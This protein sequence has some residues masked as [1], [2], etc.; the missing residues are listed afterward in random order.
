MAD[1]NIQRTTPTINI[2][3]ATRNYHLPIA[4]ATTLGGIKVG[5]N[6]TI[7]ED[8]TLNSELTEYDL[9]VA[10]S[11]TLGG[12]KIGSSLSI[13]DGVA[14]VTVDS[15]LDSDSSNPLRNSV[16]TSYINDL[17]SAIQDAGSSLTSLST[18]VGTLSNTV[19]AHTTAISTM[20]NTL[21]AHTSAIQANSDNISTQ[22][23]SISNNTYAIGEL[24][25]RLINA[26]GSITT[27]SDSLDV[28][29]ADDITTLQSTDLS[30]SSTWT[31]GNI[32]V[33]KRGNVGYLF[34]DLEGSLTIAA[35]SSEVI[36]TFTDLIP[37]VK[38]SSTLLTD[39]GT[40][41]GEFDDYTY[42]LS[43]INLDT[44]HAI[45][46]TKVKGCIPVVFA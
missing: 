12:I 7:E 15:S 20:D 18:T 33:V 5:T 44:Q 29:T 22:A 2:D 38:A 28:L 1:I 42:N 35:D 30:P 16:V 8:G 34:I 45:T 27:M 6:L 37:L 14:S 17:T 21:D 46:L 24:D 13:A 39:G 31:S 26:E 4:S 32:N 10:T 41:I 23:T 43:L 36:Y 19:S 3:A 9:P 25:T 11:S 40:I